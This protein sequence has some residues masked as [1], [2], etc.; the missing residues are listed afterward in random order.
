MDEGLP[1]EHDATSLGQVSILNLTCAAGDFGPVFNPAAA[2]RDTR[3]WL[4]TPC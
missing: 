2:P 4:A 3:S 1:F